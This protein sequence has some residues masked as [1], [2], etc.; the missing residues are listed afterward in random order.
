MKS[1]LLYVSPF[2]LLISGGPSKT[3]KEYKVEV[4]A[5]DF[6]FAAPARIPYGWITFV[7]DN[8]N[9]THVHELS[10]SKLPEGINYREYR[11]KF[12][13]SW[14]T[15][16]KELQDGKIDISDFYSRE[17]ELLPEWADQMEYLT[18]RGLV[19]PGQ[20]V[21]K[22]IYLEPGHYSLECWVKT[23]DGFIHV[24]KGM[25]TPLT[26][27]ENSANSSEPE[28]AEKITVTKD[29]IKTKWNPSLGKHSFALYL[30]G[31]STGMPVHNNIH[32]I[33]TGINTDLTKVNKWL[34]WY[35][36]GGL[37]SPAP[38]VFLGGLSTYKL[39]VGAHPEYFTVYFNEPGEYA[40]VVEVPAGQRLW[41][42]FAVN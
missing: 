32:L 35:H 40:W 9:A 16:L 5:A 39:K 7:L 34:D 33:K 41:K 4:K 17:Q 18:S 10:I 26:V 3:V 38:A 2:L 19:S 31:D 27:T 11:D 24:S 37:R 30:E 25:M 15:I 8:E 12:I 36:V 42:T 23:S 22:T 20:K 21:E 13:G 29:Q 6:A 14:E 1:L 28:P